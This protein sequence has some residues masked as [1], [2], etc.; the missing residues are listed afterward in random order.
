VSAF[1]LVLTVVSAI[2][3]AAPV[4]AQATHV[5]G[6]GGSVTEVD[7]TPVEGVQADLFATADDGTRGDYLGSVKSEA[8]GMFGFEVRPGCYTVTVIAPAGRT[9]N[10][11]N[12]YQPSVCVAD[13]EQVELAPGVLDPIPDAAFGGRVTT[14]S[15]DPAEGVAIDLFLRNDRGGRGAYLGSTRT[16]ANGVY[17]FEV[18][19]GCYIITMIAPDGQS[20]PTGAYY[21]PEACTDGGGPADDLNAVLTD[22]VAGETGLGGQVTDGVGA[23]APGVAIDLFNTGADGSRTDFIRTLTT[24]DDGRFKSLL[25]PGCYWLVYI[26]PAGQTFNGGQYLE[27]F[28]CLD[29]GQTVDDLDAMLDPIGPGDVS[30][31]IADA[32]VA[33]GDAGEQNQVELTVT[34]SGPAP[35]PLSVEVQTTDGTAT[36]GEDYEAAP[37]GTELTIPAGATSVGGTVTVLGDDAVEGDETFTVQLVNPSAGLTLADD[38][39]Q[40][41]I[42]DDDDPVTGNPPSIDDQQFSVIEYSS[43][44]TVIGTVAATSNSGGTLVYSLDDSSVVAIDSATGEL[45]VVDPLALAPDTTVT[46]QATVDDGESASA[47]ISIDVTRIDLLPNPN[48]GTTTNGATLEVEITSPTDRTNTPSGPLTIEGLAG[49]DGTSGAASVTYVVDVSRSTSFGRNDCN[50]DGVVDEGDNFNPEVDSTDGRILDCEIAGLLALNRSLARFDVEVSLVAFAGDA[51]VADVS[52]AEGVQLFTS[53]TADVD[54][55]GVADIEE[56]LTGLGIERITQFEDTNVRSGTRFDRA[57]AAAGGVMEQRQPGRR[58]FFFFLSDGEDFGSNSALDAETA[59]L[60]EAG[61]LVNT[62]AVAEPESRCADGADLARLAAGT[63]GACEVVEDPSTLT[64]ALTEAPENIESVVVSIDG[65]EPVPATLTAL[66]QWS[67]EVAEPGQG[68]HVVR[69]TVRS[70]DGTEVA[71]EILALRFG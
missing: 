66:G 64:A 59:L 61:I 12:W 44:G 24:G 69:A 50:G 34:L 19:S 35:G 43:V 65:G 16:D 10:G 13:G 54:G 39:A 37:A 14:E 8:N 48:Q 70:D 60:A 28:Q 55:N 1:A 52:P 53:P 26:A 29:P 38:T 57:L 40:V 20:F 56:V 5:A 6:I 58:G 9:F 27:K 62:F 41:T 3:G 2:V 36:A 18:A 21:Q 49:L 33:E 22:P 31:T 4:S 17:T 46:V 15:G 30:A 25:D 67:V 7:G 23:P 68:R 71:A 11:R 63:G 45:T 51:E 42:V 47:E 32:R